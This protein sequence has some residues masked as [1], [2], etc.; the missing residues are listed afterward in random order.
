MRPK[1]MKEKLVELADALYEKREEELGA[2]NMRLLERVVMLRTVDS[3]WV[4]HL[5]AMENM[6]LEAGWQTLR[7]IKA[8]DAYKNE[9]YKQFQVLLSTIKHDVAHTIYHAGVVKKEAQPVPSV[10][11]QAAAA[12]AGTYSPQPLKAAGQKAGRNDPCPCGSGKK[13][14]KCCGT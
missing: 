11:A 1:E 9:G 7:Q 8:V 10:M 14:K 12:R 4:E 13:Y 6:R 5:T 3:L 2:D